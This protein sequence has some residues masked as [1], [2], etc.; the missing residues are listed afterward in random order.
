[1]ALMRNAAE[2]IR[3]GVYP[4]KWR[5]PKFQAK[6]SL[7]TFLS[8]I[9]VGL[10]DFSGMFFPTWQAW[11]MSTPVAMMG[12]PEAALPSELECLEN[13]RWWVEGDSPS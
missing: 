12:D 5:I 8:M 4:S 11:D 1:M 10:K 3:K 6:A 13:L 2:H 9:L 7:I